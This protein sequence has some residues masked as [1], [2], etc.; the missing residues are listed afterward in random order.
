VPSKFWQ[1]YNATA[2]TGFSLFAAGL[3][4]S[5]PL[6]LLR[7]NG[8]EFWMLSNRFRFLI[9]SGPSPSILS[10][11][12]R[13]NLGIVIR[14]GFVSC[15]T[16]RVATILGYSESGS[17]SAV[18]NREIKA[19]NENSSRSCVPANI[20]NRDP[21]QGLWSSRDASILVWIAFSEA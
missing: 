13:P 10:F 14:H 4:S 11:L 17:F 3:E 15:A 7:N 12:I 6:S 16:K 2:F 8:G 19:I 21:T 9:C 5:F 1:I 20:L 18:N